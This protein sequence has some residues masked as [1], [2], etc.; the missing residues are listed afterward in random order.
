MI[1]F[2]KEFSFSFNLMNSAV[3]KSQQK[4]K[5]NE[6]RK[7]NNKQKIKTIEKLKCVPE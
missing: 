5:T 7:K 6:F 3:K 4:L 2:V 1:L